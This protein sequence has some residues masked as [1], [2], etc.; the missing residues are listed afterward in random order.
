M[1]LLIRLITSAAL[2]TCAL[3]CQHTLE[4]DNDFL[5]SSDLSLVIKGTTVLTYNPLTWQLGYN[6]DN[7]EFQANDDSMNDYFLVKCSSVPNKV[8]QKLNATVTWQVK[9]SVKSSDGDFEVVKND[10]DTY[11]LWCGKK[12]RRIAV[13]VRVLR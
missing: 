6:S 10:G 7:K 3:S 1:K 13:T 8:G 2:L 4:P 5:V 9:G 11:W 12:N